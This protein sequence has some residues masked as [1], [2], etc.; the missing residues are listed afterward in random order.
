MMRSFGVPYC[1][2]Y[3]DEYLG[4]QYVIQYMTCRSCRG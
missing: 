3:D 2:F 1:T 4:G